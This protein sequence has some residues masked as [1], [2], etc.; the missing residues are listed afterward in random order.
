M[1]P[2]TGSI[3]RKR[4]YQYHNWDVLVP[5]AK[6]LMA[7]GLSQSAA[8]K[9]LGLPQKTL[10]HAMRMSAPAVHHS[11]PAPS[12]NRDDVTVRTDDPSPLSAPEVH[13]STLALAALESRLSVV[14]AFIATL[15]R[16]P[17]YL[18]TNG[19]G[20]PAVHHS[21]PAPRRWQK[22]GAEFDATQRAQLQTYAKAHGLQVREV[23]YE[24]L[25]AFFAAREVAP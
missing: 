14:E 6:A 22:T 15:Q 5:Q 13:P 23:V 1:A 7:G 2:T 20:A 3:P 12:P 11:A 19:H 4:A 25:S 16:E 9:Q 10:W 18:P 8:A 17:A 24:A 21:A